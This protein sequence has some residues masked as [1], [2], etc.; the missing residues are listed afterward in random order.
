MYCCEIACAVILGGTSRSSVGCRGWGSVP[1]GQLHPGWISNLNSYGDR[2][3]FFLNIGSHLCL[4]FFLPLPVY[5]IQSLLFV[6]FASLSFALIPLRASYP[7]APLF[8]DP[9]EGVPRLLGFLL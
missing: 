5:S 8:Q 1:R 2:S 4:L 7:L 3:W 6:L 9:P